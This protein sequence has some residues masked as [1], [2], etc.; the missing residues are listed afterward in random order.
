MADEQ[1]AWLEAGD[2]KR[3]SI[4]G[5]LSIGRSAKNTVVIDS[6]KDRAVV[7]DEFRQ[8]LER[9]LTFEFIIARQP[10]HAHSAAPERPDQG[11]A[12]KK[13]LPA[14]KLTQR[15]IQ[16]VAGGIVSHGPVLIPWPRAIRQDLF[17]GPAQMLPVKT[18]PATRQ[19][20]APTSLDGTAAGT[21]SALSA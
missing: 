14:G 8:E 17:P 7:D 12:A 21:Y 3:I 2:Q 6:P 16:S 10:H 9:D 1:G 13:L 15:R 11:V 4:L 18:G 20:G 19:N 5:N